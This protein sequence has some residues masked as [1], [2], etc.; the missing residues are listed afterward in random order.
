VGREREEQRVP[1]GTNRGEESQDSG[2]SGEEAGD[3]ASDDVFPSPVDPS[4][5]CV[6]IGSQTPDGSVARPPPGGPEDTGEKEG[7][8]L[9]PDGFVPRLRRPDYR[10][11]GKRVITGK[12]PEHRPE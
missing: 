4:Y 8:P 5:D 3:E 2:Q 10:L 12:P 9:C 6:P 7:R 1:I 11:W